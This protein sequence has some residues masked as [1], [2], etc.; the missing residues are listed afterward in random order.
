M[1]LSIHCG[2][3]GIWQ[4][5][6]IPLPWMTQ[7]L[8][9]VLIRVLN[10]IGK[11]S[12]FSKFPLSSIVLLQMNPQTGRQQRESFT[13]P[14]WK[15]YDSTMFLSRIITSRYIAVKWYLRVYWLL[16]LSIVDSFAE[17]RRF[18]WK[19]S[20]TLLLS[21][22]NTWASQS[23]SFPK[24][25]ISCFHRTLFLFINWISRQLDRSHTTQ[26]TPPTRPSCFFVNKTFISNI[27]NPGNLQSR[28][29]ISACSL[30]GRASMRRSLSL[31]WHP[32]RKKR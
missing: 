1:T 4:A 23:T 28:A 32:A 25:V 21:T 17:N 30:G 5:L 16:P 13:K 31:D 2:N 27:L 11:T 18:F 22:M 26:Q 19:A 24:G 20:T 6:P 3:W 12:I 8:A 29:K 15:N 7:R 9:G 10:L 14:K